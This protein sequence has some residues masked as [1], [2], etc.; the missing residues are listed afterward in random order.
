MKKFPLNKLVTIILLISA[1]NVFAIPCPF[2]KIKTCTVQRDILN[3]KA[4]NGLK[5]YAPTNYDHRMS[6]EINVYNSG[7]VQPYQDGT[8]T[9]GQLKF[10]LNKIN[11]GY[12][13]SGE[14]MTRANLNQPP[15]NAPGPSMPWT[16]KEIKHGYIEVV[17][18]FPKCDASSDGLCQ[19]GTNPANYSAGLW[20]AI[21]MMPT[22]DG[23]WP[24][25]GEID[26]SEA[27]PKDSNFTYSTAA[28]HFFGNS[29]SCGGGDCVGPGYPLGKG[30]NGSP[31]YQGFHSWGFE[32]QPD[33]A[34]TTGGQIITGYFDGSKIWGPLRTDTLPADGKNA[35]SRGFNDPNGG[36]YLIVNSA[37]GGPYAGYP[38]SVMQ[39]ANMYVQSAKAYIVSDAPACSPPI[40]IQSM[41]SPDK[42]QLTMAWGAPASTGKILYYRVNDWQNKPM[43]QGTSPSQ[44]AFQDQTLPGTSGK[45]TYYLYTICEGST[46]AAQKYDAQ[47]PL[48]R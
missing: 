34:S 32:W 6:G 27:Y 13:L 15:F 23:N 5:Y 38:N 7:L 8:N 33:P 46:S 42:T 20:P 26:I 3:D 14:F 1:A 44:R 18:K 2:D 24:Q 48:Q 37:I 40:N 47:V 45:F 9:P 21:W 16:T 35:L 30:T 4:A 41:I 36:Y 28:L 11:N 29:P 31:L 17:S 12:Y 39:N 22:N 43:W 10:V 19:A 25:N